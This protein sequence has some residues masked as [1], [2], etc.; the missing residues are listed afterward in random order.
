MSGK[1]GGDSGLSER[2]SQYAASLAKFINDQDIPGTVL[3]ET[4]RHTSRIT[5]SGRGIKKKNRYRGWVMSQ[6]VLAFVLSKLLL[7]QEREY[8]QQFIHFFQLVGSFC[9][10]T[11]LL[12]FDLKQFSPAEGS[13]I[14]KIKH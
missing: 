9:V 6:I 10:S 4:L 13:L 7:Y 14:I 5:S 8:Y 1:I 12:Y 2:G 11:A 3:S